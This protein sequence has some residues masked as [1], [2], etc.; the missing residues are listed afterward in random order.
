MKLMVFDVGGTD[1]KYSVMDESLERENMGSVPTPQDTRENFFK[2]LKDIFDQFKD[3][4]DGVAMSLPGFI[5]S[6]K[7][8]CNGGGWLKYNQG[9]SIGPELSEYLGAPVHLANDGKA[10]ALAE[11]KRGSLVGCENAAVYI[12][13]TGIGGGLIINGEIVNGKHFTAGELSLLHTNFDKWT[14]PDC[15][16]GLNCSYRSLIKMYIKEAG[17]AEDTKLNGKEFFDI[18]KSGN[19]IADR[20][21]DE[22]AMLNA[23]NILNL[24]YLLDFE[25]VAI[26][27][28][29]SRQP[30]LIERINAAVDKLCK[31]ADETYGF[32]LPRPEIVL[33]SYLSDANMVGAYLYYQHDMK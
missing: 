5:D 19:E 2:A 13:G 17:L 1:I 32:S 7:G 8:R 31:E 23:K 27:G 30:V 22:Y 3:E 11:L 14:D 10:A 18:L 29:I 26:G 28:G 20:V 6:K 16:T 21:L 15:M 24:N 25:K 33:C 4:V 12:I 9:M